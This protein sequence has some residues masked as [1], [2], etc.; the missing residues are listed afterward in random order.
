MTNSD[1]RTTRRKALQIGAAAA[2]AAVVGTVVTAAVGSDRTAASAA[3]SGS[4]SDYGATGRVRGI[5]DHNVDLD[6]LAGLSGPAATRVV[7]RASMPLIGFSSDTLPRIGDL[8]A[9]SKTTPGYDRAAAPMIHYVKGVP[10]A[11][12]AGGFVIAG[13]RI[14][15][16]P[17]LRAAAKAGTS[18]TASVFDTHLPVTQVFGVRSV[19]HR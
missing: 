15:D 7:G 3:E 9:V 13:E 12:G 11:S 16:H 10:R 19:E 4:P 1:G 17:A 2:S 18:I 6:L 14:A 8:V 5:A